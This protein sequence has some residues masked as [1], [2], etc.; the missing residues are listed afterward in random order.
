M[1]S[2]YD[3]MML[4]TVTG[5]RVVLLRDSQHELPQLSNCQLVLA[6]LHCGLCLAYATKGLICGELK[7]EFK[8]GNSGASSVASSTTVTP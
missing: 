4:Y 3:N 7:Y 1:C 2:M 6:L 8:D 5:L